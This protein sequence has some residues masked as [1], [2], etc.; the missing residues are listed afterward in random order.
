M[1]V[2]VDYIIV[3]QG[4]AGSALAWE[5]IKR[6]KRIVVFD[7]PSVNRSS[8]IAAGICNPITSKGMSKTFL[9]DKLFPFLQT[10]YKASEDFLGEK[11][12]TALPVYRPFL[13]SAERTQWFERSTQE[14]L[15]MF[16]DRV[17]EEPY[18]ESKLNNP[19]GGL[20]LKLSGMLNVPR[21]IA[22]VRDM[23]RTQGVY[24]EERVSEEEVEAGD[25][26]R[27]Q[28]IRAS[29]IIFCQGLTTR[30][31]R[32][33]NWLPIRPLKGETLTV[34]MDFPEEKILSRGVY[35]VPSGVPGVFTAG[36]T[37]QHE[38]FT[39]DP[40]AE[41]L[42]HIQDRLRAM[43]R[44]PF[45]VLHQDWGIRPTVTDRRPILGAH[46]EQPNVIIFNGL[47]TKGV[48][49]SPYFASVL[50]GWMDGGDALPEE[51]NISRFKSLYSN[52]W[53]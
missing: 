38:P 47:G 49:L 36:S 23:L 20:E 11:F 6:G 46:P 24:R 35:L 25:E 52:G 30:E 26:I 39:R 21:W 15:R 2:S 41:G 17:W 3:G 13:S 44:V 29:R 12:F 22:S 45:E 48:S 19:H 27:Y 50:A 31:S 28:D 7:E 51:V 43:I 34:K 32:W 14:E 8:V 40:T 4:L 42:K 9:A 5:C 33:F 37:Y 18:C 16:V 1:S 53:L 10:W